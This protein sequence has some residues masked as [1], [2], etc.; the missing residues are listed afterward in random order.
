M[1]RGQRRSGALMSAVKDGAA[2][3]LATD[4]TVCVCMATLTHTRGEKLCACNH[5][6]LQNTEYLTHYFNSVTSYVKF[7]MSEEMQQHYCD[8]C[9]CFLLCIIVLH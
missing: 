3:P 1:D 8:L 4:T 2:V 7:H 6:N 5:E 9:C